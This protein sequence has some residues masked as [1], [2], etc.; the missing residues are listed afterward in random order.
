M[1]TL[2]VFGL[3]FL[4]SCESY[5]GKVPEG[6]KLNYQELAIPLANDPLLK[7][8]QHKI[9]QAFVQGMTTQ[10]PKALGQLA[11][12]LRQR[13][14]QKPNNLIMYWCSY[15][16]YYECIFHLTR[17]EKK[18]AE[19]KIDQAVQQMKDLAKKNSEDYALLAMLQSL[20][21]QFKS[22]MKAPFISSSVQKHANFSLA[23]DSLNPRAYYVMGSNDFYTPEQYGGRAKAESLLQKAIALPSQAV[24]NALLPSWG[25]EEA[26]ALLIKFYMQEERWTDAKKVFK[27]A[28]ET[29]PNN[30]QINQ[31]AAKLIDK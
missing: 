18:Q 9:Y 2:L 7:D 11:Q 25:V 15:A 17:E 21:I 14:E 31:M 23:L 27:A 10:S 3:I 26:Y 16:N 1:R 29:Y 28:R 30:Y 13:Y 12:E 5:S 20:S 22:S 8:I 6:E 19:A 4:I 24:P